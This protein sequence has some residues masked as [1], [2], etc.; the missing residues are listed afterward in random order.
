MEVEVLADSDAAAARAAE[1]IAAAGAEAGRERG[2]FSLAV[3]GGRSPG[4]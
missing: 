2:S 3:S 1:V 4:G